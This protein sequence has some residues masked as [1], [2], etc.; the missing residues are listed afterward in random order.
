MYDGNQNHST[1]GLNEHT[2]L[3][4]RKVACP[5]YDLPSEMF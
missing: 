4:F 1:G 5:G 3:F 2:G